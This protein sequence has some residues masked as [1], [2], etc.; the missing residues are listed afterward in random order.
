MYEKALNWLDIVQK[1]STKDEDEF[2]MSIGTPQG[3]NLSKHL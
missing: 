3:R 1:W 2:E